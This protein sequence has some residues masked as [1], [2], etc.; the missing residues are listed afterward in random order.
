M[1]AMTADKLNPTPKV[2]FQKIESNLKAHYNL[3]EDPAFDRAEEMALLN[4]TRTLSEQMATT[5]NPQVLGMVNAW[6]LAGVQ[7]FLHEFRT[8]AEKQVVVT[9]PGL[10]RTLNHTNS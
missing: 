7:E 3:L 9:P 8:L 10:A 4:Y 2:R 5:Q 6:K 1:I